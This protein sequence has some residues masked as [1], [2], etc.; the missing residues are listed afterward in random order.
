M[1]SK[2]ENSEEH[3]HFLPLPNRE[4]VGVRVDVDLL[5]NPHPRIKSGAGSSPL[6]FKEREQDSIDFG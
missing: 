2:K 1:K 5:L 4:R 3:T 6:L